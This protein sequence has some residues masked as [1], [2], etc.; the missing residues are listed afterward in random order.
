MRPGVNHTEIRCTLGCARRLDRRDVGNMLQ[1]EAEEVGTRRNFLLP[2]G[3]SLAGRCAQ[4]GFGPP[5]A[6]ARCDADYGDDRS[7]GN[8]SGHAQQLY[9]GE[10]LTVSVTQYV[11]RCG[12]P[13]TYYREG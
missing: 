9:V 4:Y 12:N 10:R 2:I 7:H 11:H 6:E 13:Q 1:T 3:L 5:V 8:E